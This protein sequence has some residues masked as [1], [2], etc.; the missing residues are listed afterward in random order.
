MAAIGTVE[1]AGVNVNRLSNIVLL[2]VLAALGYLLSKLAVGLNGLVENDT[3]AKDAHN[4][5]TVNY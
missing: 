1:L 5:A 3:L 2:N 4:E